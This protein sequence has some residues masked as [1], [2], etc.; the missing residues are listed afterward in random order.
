M[1]DFRQALEDLPL[2]DKQGYLEALERAPMAVLMGPGGECHPSIFLQAEQGNA[3]AAAERFA[4]YWELRRW[5]FGEDERAWLPLTAT[6]NGALSPQDV[7]LLQTGFLT[8]LPQEDK[9]GRGVLCFQVPPQKLNADRLAMA[10]VT[11]YVL[12]LALQTRP[13]VVQHGLVVVADTK[14]Y[15]MERYDRKFLKCVAYLFTGGYHPATIKAYHITA[16][17]GSKSCFQLAMPFLRY[18]MIRHIR[19]RFRLHTGTTQECAL[20]LQ[21]FGI[22]TYNLPVPMGGHFTHEQFLEWLFLEEGP[23]RRMEL[24]REE[25][26]VESLGLREDEDDE[27]SHN[28]GGGDGAMMDGLQEDVLPPGLHHNEH[29]DLVNVNGSLISLP[30]EIS[31]AIQKSTMSSSSSSST[32]NNNNNNNNNRPPANIVIGANS[33]GNDNMV[34]S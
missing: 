26:Y 13:L 33:K 8:L 18:F 22:A 3:W 23:V 19:Q 2:E 11:F 34:M 14:Y 21:E 29:G 25:A 4:N 16:P 15:T 5:L 10:R 7:E 30:H 24:Q 12:S 1:Q 17:P 9:H 27:E 32:N 6:G 20:D 28:E 31:E